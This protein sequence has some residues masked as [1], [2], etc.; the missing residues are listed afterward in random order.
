[1]HGGANQNQGMIFYTHNYNIS[2]HYNN[3]G[4]DDNMYKI[5]LFE[6]PEDTRNVR[7]WNL[8][9][10]ANSDIF[11]R[12]HDIPKYNNR[13][14]ISCTTPFMDLDEENHLYAVGHM[15]I[16]M[17][18]YL[19][20]RL[21]IRL[22]I[23]PGDGPRDIPEQAMN[24]A[25]NYYINEPDHL[26]RSGMSIIEWG[27]L[28]LRNAV[29]QQNELLLIKISNPQNYPRDAAQPVCY[30]LP[31]FWV[32]RELCRQRELILFQHKTSGLISSDIYGNVDLFNPIT[33]R[34]WHPHFMYYMFLYAINK[35]TLVLQS[36]SHPF[37]ILKDDKSAALNFPMGLT[38]NHINIDG[39]YED[40][41][42]VWLSY[43]EGDC[44]CK[45]A[46]FTEEQFRNK[47]NECDNGTDIN[48]LEF[49]VWRD[50]EI[51]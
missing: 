21:R 29:G 39:D 47:V 49:R 12:I 28:Q 26:F 9:L 33:L 18:E 35:S 34:N 46:A 15:K 17:W 27:A 38:T 13:L 43:G 25:V 2:Q 23:S 14:H 8:R 31:R 37:M 11:N 36:F 3:I 6:D 42:H 4:D 40:T 48:T 44:Q 1:M 45:I 32:V 5:P 7:S 22:R 41:R 51:D 20:Q 50:G 24:D 30:L 10:P 16:N 19:D